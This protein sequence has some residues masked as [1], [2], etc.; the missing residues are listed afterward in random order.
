MDSGDKSWMGLRRS[1]NEYISGV[2]NFLDTTFERASKGDE[3][4]C[5]FKKC[6]NCK[7]N[8]RN[9]VEDHLVVYGFVQGYT[10]WIFHGESFSSR[11]HP[12]HNNK[13]GSNMRDNIDGLLH[14]T[15]RDVAGDLRLEGVREGLSEDAKK[16]FKL[17]EEGKQEL[18]HG[19]ENFSKLNFTI[20]LFLFKCIHG[21][22]N[23]AFGDL[24]D[25]LREAFPFSH[26]PESFHKEKNV[27]KD[28]GV[29]YEKIHACPN[30]CMLF[31]KE[32]E[33]EN[34]CSVCGSSRWKTVNDPLTNESSK[35]PTKVLRYL[36]LKP[37]LQRIFM[38]PETTANMK[39]HDTE[40]P[41]DGNIW[42][43]ADGEAWKKFDSLHEDFARD[44]RN[45]R[46]GLS[47]DGFNPFR[48]MTLLW[49]ISDFPAYAM[50][51]GWS[52][53]GRKACPTCNH[54]T[55]SQYLKHSRKMCYMGHRAL[56][57]PDHPF[58]RDKKS[59]DGKEDHRSAPTPLSGT[60]VLEELREFNNV[61]GK[62]QKRKH[63]DSEG[64]WKKR[65][66]FF[67]LPYWEHN[68]LRHNLDVMHIEKNICDSLL[69][70]LLDVTGKSK[71]HVNSR[72][73]LQEIGIR[74]ELQPV[75]DDNGRVHLDKACCVSNISRCV[76]VDEM[77]ILGYKSHDAHFIM[78]YLLQI[79]VRKVLPKKVS[80]ALIRLGN[81]FKVI[82]SKVI[83]RADLDTMQ[84]EIYEI[85]CD[86]EKI[87]PPSFFDIMVH[88]PIHLVNEIKLGGPIHLRW[89][90]STER[91]LCFFKGH[92]RN[93]F[94]LE[95][96]I[97][98]GFVALESV[99]LCSRYLHAGVKTKF[100]RYQ[101]ED[102]QGTETEGGNLSPIFPKFGHPIGREKKSKGNNFHMDLQLCV[103]IHRYVLFNTGDEKMETFIM[104]HKIVIDNH[105]RS[106]AW[107]RAQNHSQEFGNWFK[108]KVKSVEVPEHLRQLTKGPNTAAK[109][110]TTYFINGYRF[111]TMKRD[112]QGK[113]Q[114]YEVTLSATTDSFASARDQNP[115][116]GEV[117]YYG[118]I[119]D[120]IEI[121]YWGCFSVVLFKCDWFRNEVDEYGL[122][123][124]YF[125]K[126]CSTED[127]FVLASQVHQ[128]FY[129]E[130]PIE[131]DVYYAR[132]KVHVDLFDLEEENCPNIG[133]TF[134]GEPDN[135]IGPS[136]GIPDADVDLRW[137]REDVPG[138]VI[139]MPTHDQHSE[140]MEEDMDTS[141]ED[142]DFDDVDWDWMVADD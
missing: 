105:S 109:R 44:P 102:E 37:R 32:N 130:D 83:R 74:K 97:L 23:V 69:G 14:D 72:Y 132:T 65:S 124:V 119:Q 131:K 128:V 29:D 62:G 26:I 103:D 22:S 67:E 94:H 77:K 115:I 31:W 95:A 138:D 79:A 137:S 80:M 27:I 25:L 133:E 117:V 1:T 35:I 98:E 114:N 136:N 88:L 50:L 108:E 106:N 81:F 42:H 12:D 68:K 123:R 96:S 43:A 63:R 10:K 111:H 34:N 129:V 66:I 92:V 76:E 84:S 100:S 125:N 45:V 41:K 20:R 140:Y 47:S 9:V 30:D 90:Y 7:W 75:Q 134:F 2:N 18:Y 89:M 46:L 135:D 93:R 121:D 56:L 139:D 71:D 5:P 107:I 142:E 58:R 120:I 13:E 126:L 99:N 6:A 19:C 4:L 101:L 104:E 38:C 59:F 51:S 53:K 60:E 91:N 15:F 61:F 40:R 36:P 87:F 52:T 110:Y 127:P 8:H 49:T 86:L 39:W 55:C 11:N 16:F 73:D 70:T 54:G 64:P 17:L 122:T 3:I 33:K 116:D 85:I 113:T 21:L 82:S 112:S 24:L 57:P 48:T 141:E 78:H 118:V 28:L